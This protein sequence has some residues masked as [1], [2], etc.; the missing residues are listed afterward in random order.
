MPLL[1]MASVRVCNT[2][3]I[4]CTCLSSCSTRVKTALCSTDLI[5][6]LDLISA[7]RDEILVASQYTQP[8]AGINNTLITS[9]NCSIVNGD[10]VT[11]MSV[12]QCNSRNDWSCGRSDVYCSSCCSNKSR[13]CWLSVVVYGQCRTCRC[14]DGA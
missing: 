5:S 11:S 14:S 2:F 1:T 3:R 7:S 13:C 12:Y 6:L 4:S 9:S 8:P 10:V